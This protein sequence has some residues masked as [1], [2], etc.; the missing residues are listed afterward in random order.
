MRPSRKKNIQSIANAPSPDGA[1]IKL[2]A[3]T[4]TNTG[5][6]DDTRC[7]HLAQTNQDRAQWCWQAKQQQFALRLSRIG[8]GGREEGGGREKGVCI[9]IR[10]LQSVTC[11][12]FEI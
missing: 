12:K 2:N 11:L 7:T 8:R 4:K 6:E 1:H 5:W 9:K 10:T 3:W